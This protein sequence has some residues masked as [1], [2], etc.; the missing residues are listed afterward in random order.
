MKVKKTLYSE[1]NN[2]LNLLEDYYKS[3]YKSEHKNY[4]IKNISSNG[5]S[6]EKLLNNVNEEIY[7]CMKCD[8]HK[9]RNMAVP[10]E[11][12]NSPLV[13][14]IG[15]GPG[16]EEDRTGRPFVGRAGQYLDKWLGAV[17]INDKTNLSRKINVFIA[18]IIKCRPPGNRDPQ[19][20]EITQCR[21]YLEKQ[22]ELLKPKAIFTISRFAAQ[23]LLNK[24]IGIT[25]LRGTVYQYKGIP[26]VPSYH[27]SAVLRNPELRAPVWDDLNLLKTVLEKNL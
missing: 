5:I 7:K 15:E 11:G 14:V 13:L 25:R 4:S 17:K 22:I 1:Y 23:L 26:L 20:D 21:P 6:P 8:L 2:L 19:Q 16:A 3:G 10:G 9:T 12:V 18:N 27:P 24:T